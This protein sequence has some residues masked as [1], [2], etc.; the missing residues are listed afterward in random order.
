[1]KKLLSVLAMVCLV[2]GASAQ[3][4]KARTCNLIFIGNSITEG[5]LHANKKKTAPPVVAANLVGN[6]LSMDVHYRNCGRS[7]ATTVDFLP[8]QKRDFVRVEKAIEEIKALSYAPILFSIMLGTNDSA[9]FGPNGS[10]VSNEDYKKN[11][12]TMIGRIRELCPNAIF[13][14][15]RPIWYSPNTHNAAQYLVAGQKRMVAYTDVLIEIANENE[16]VYLGDRDAFDYFGAKHRKYMFAE[17]GKAG[18]FYLHPNEAGARKLARYW[19]QAIVK[20]VKKNL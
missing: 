10:P 15:Q 17:D 6:M 20:V 7:G 14:L 4:R 18:T 11:L 13:I 8:E 5:A 16:D 1:M 3:P 12:M 19:A 2:L 9:N